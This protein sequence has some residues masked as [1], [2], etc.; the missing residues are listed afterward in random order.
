PRD[1]PRP[2]R[3]R[4]GCLLRHLAPTV[5]RAD[6]GCPGT[7]RRRLETDRTALAREA[8]RRGGAGLDHDDV[9]AAPSH[10]RCRGPA[11]E[12]GWGAPSEGFPRCGNHF[13]RPGVGGSC[14]SWWW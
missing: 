5:R 12:R 1:D 4:R 10:V 6:R 14:E 11:L 9:G 7:L 13:V 2:E 3:A 8:I